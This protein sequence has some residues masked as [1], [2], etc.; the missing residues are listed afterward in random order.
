MPRP[1]GQ[2]S[3][4][5]DLDSH[6]AQGI[7]QQSPFTRFFPSPRGF[8]VLN[9]SWKAAHEIQL[10]HQYSLTKATK[11]RWACPPPHSMCQPEKTVCSYHPAFSAYTLQRRLVLVGSVIHPAPPSS[12]RIKKVKDA[13]SRDLLI[14]L[15]T[16]PAFYSSQEHETHLSFLGRPGKL[17]T[18]ALMPANA[19]KFPRVTGHMFL[20]R[21]CKSG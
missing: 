10:T 7:K 8:P 1:T 4:D 2:P 13:E 20:L 3:L 15:L 14:S 16:T 19:L 6:P 5:P 9:L 17:L 18:T 12:I 11:T 21:L